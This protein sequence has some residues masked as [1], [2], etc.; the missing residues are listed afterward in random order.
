METQEKLMLELTQLK[1]KNI[2][3]K[4]NFDV[5]KIILDSHFKNSDRFLQ[6]TTTDT[7][8]SI[9]DFLSENSDYF[10]SQDYEAFVNNLKA[11]T[12]LSNIPNFKN[13]KKKYVNTNFEYGDYEQFLEI[14]KVQS[15][16]MMDFLTELNDLIFQHRYYFTMKQNLNKKLFDKLFQNNNWNFL[17]GLRV[18]LNNNKKNL[19][20]DEKMVAF[21]ENDYLTEMITKTAEDKLN[22]FVVEEVLITI[23]QIKLGLILTIN[24]LKKWFVE[25]E[26]III[27]NNDEDILEF[28]YFMKEQKTKSNLL[29]SKNY[30]NLYNIFGALEDNEKDNFKAKAFTEKNK[31]DDIEELLKIESQSKIHFEIL[32][33]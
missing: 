24:D 1:K 6:F 14:K 3:F 2:I 17:N 20:F 21:E 7:T 13:K 5:V 15:G 9:Q 33:F 12:K 19:Y 27:K 30:G 32:Y 8:N 22:S 29:V 25:F 11:I 28:D 10:E 31:K 23:R 26:P 18:Y 4:F 16:F